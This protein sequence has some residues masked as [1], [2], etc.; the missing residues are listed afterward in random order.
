LRNNQKPPFPRHLRL[1]SRFACRFACFG[2]VLTLPACGLFADAPHYRGIEVSQHDLGELSVG[3]S[4]EA[5]AQALLGPPTF[6]EQFA[7]N[8]WDY[9][10]QVTKMLI[11]KTEGVRTQHVVVL[12]F[13]NNGILQKV[14]QKD[15]HDSVQV[16]MD[17][18][19]TPVP[20]GSA[21]IIQQ[22]I[23]GVGSYNPGLGAGSGPGAGASGLG[24]NG[25]S[26]GGNG[27]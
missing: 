6:Q 17:S 16:A 15:L 1:A 12:S 20:G 11:A 14:S 9:V 18:A 13:D 8:N 26:A 19:H 3:T 5:D 10:A 21:S 24:G 22:I 2:A 27:F 25:L 23:G 4:R 7:P